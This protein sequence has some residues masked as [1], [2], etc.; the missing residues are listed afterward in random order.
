MQSGI[1]ISNLH[2]RPLNIA[3]SLGCILGVSQ[4][5]SEVSRNCQKIFFK[6]AT[7]PWE[8]NEMSPWKIEAVTSPWGDQISTQELQEV[9]PML[10]F[11]YIFVIL[12]LLLLLLQYVCFGKIGRL[13]NRSC[14]VWAWWSSPAW[15]RRSWRRPW[16]HGFSIGGTA[17]VA[18]WQI[19]WKS[20]SKNGNWG[21]YIPNG[22]VSLWNLCHAVLIHGCYKSYKESQQKHWHM[23]LSHKMPED[24]ALSRWT[25]MAPESF[26]LTNLRRALRVLCTTKWQ[27]VWNFGDS[28][29]ILCYSHSAKICL[30]SFGCFCW[31]GCHLWSISHEWR[32]CCQAHETPGGFRW[33][34]ADGTGWAPR[35]RFV[36][37]MW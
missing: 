11:L 33:L 4:N 5:M 28:V 31:S 9:E 17:R 34:P 36:K 12:L 21:T 27:R 35:Q 15:C 6:Q 2:A 32:K 18:G 13:H 10:L 19:S 16:A 30:P 26:P 29:W 37:W 24:G 3:I 7:I 25:M 20:P 22:H 23:T 14:V 1:S 8:M